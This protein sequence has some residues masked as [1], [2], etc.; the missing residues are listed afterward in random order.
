[1]K[2][3]LALIVLLLSAQAVHAQAWYTGTGGGQQPIHYT[4]PHTI[5]DGSAPRGG[6]APFYANG[7]PDDI[8]T[9]STIISAWTSNSPRTGSCPPDSATYDFYKSAT[10]SPGT[11]GCMGPG[12][13]AKARFDCNDTFDEN[14]DAIVRFHQKGNSPHRH[15]FFGNTGAAGNMDLVDYSWLRQHGNAT[16]Y[17]GPMN[18]TLYWE[19]SMYVLKGGKT[20]VAIKAFNIIT[21][22]INPN[23]D[24]TVPSSYTSVSRWPRSLAMIFGKDPNDPL[25]NRMRN[26]LVADSITPTNNAVDAYS[27]YNGFTGWTCS[28]GAYATPSYSAQSP[29]QIQGHAQPWLNDGAGHVTLLCNP[30]A[31]GGL[32]SAIGVSAGLSSQDCW[33][34]HNSQSPDGRSH[35]AFS[36]GGSCPTGWYKIPMFQ[37]GINIVFKD[38]TELSTAYLS[39]DRMAGMPLAS[40]TGSIS[41]TTLTVPGTVTGAIIANHVLTGTGVTAGTKVV[42]GSGTTWTVDTSQTV[43]STAMTLNYN[44][45]ETMH[46]DLIPAWDYGTGDNPGFM[47]GFFQHCLGISMHLKNTDG[48][49]YTDRAGD[50]H[51]C[52]YGR[53][54]ANRVAIVNSSSPDGSLP[55]PVVNLNPDFTGT[56][57]YFPIDPG[58]TVDAIVTHKHH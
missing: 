50:P 23:S 16:C 27:I 53:I 45:G 9:S 13:E 28:N 8:P 38:N 48:V 11:N 25:N 58:T 26:Q 30:A 47:I 40:F 32:T 19:P 55:N 46:A 10:D 41:G 44:G 3:L 18:R 14:S 6:E 35:I 22:Y 36:N 7:E 2:K 37:P 1:M 57:R 43:S 15:H 31:Y 24:L 33:D 56:N 12:H 20:L 21:Y 52:G 49:T 54:D 42:S 4:S 29:Y 5:G 39:S 17:G 51:E 34:G